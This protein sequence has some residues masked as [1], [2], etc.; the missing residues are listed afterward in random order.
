[1]KRIF[2]LIVVM[3]IIV[4]TAVAA[5]AD[6]NPRRGKQVF[7]DKCRNCH[8]SGSEAGLINPLSKTQMQWRRFIH[9]DQHKLHIKK[10]LLKDLKN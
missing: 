6:G 9:R 8:V 1:M 7:M 5:L 10:L 2:S 3:G 4:V